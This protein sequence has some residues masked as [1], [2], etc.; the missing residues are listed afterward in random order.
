MAIALTKWEKTAATDSCSW[1]LIVHYL[2][3]QLTSTSW[4]K[5]NQKLIF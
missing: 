5:K 2:V 4:H 1:H 3:E